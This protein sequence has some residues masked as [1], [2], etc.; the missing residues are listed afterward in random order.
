[1]GLEGKGE[2]MYQDQDG[3][4][5]LNTGETVLL[6]VVLGEYKINRDCKFIKFY[7]KK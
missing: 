2:M 5:N 4:I 3:S 7:I 6:S 1:M